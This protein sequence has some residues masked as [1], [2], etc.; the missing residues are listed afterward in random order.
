[1]IA[2]NV[3]KLGRDNIDPRKYMKRLDKWQ[4]RVEEGGGDWRV[5]N[6]LDNIDRIIKG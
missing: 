3:T 4:Q 5:I 1:M 2:L 6:D